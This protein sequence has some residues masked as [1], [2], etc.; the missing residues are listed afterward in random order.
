MTE[1]M[2]EKTQEKTVD[3][4]A[5]QIVMLIGACIVISILTQDI[6]PIMFVV[7]VFVGMCIIA[8]GFLSV[9]LRSA[10][11]LKKQKGKSLVKRKEFSGRCSR[12]II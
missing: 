6:S 3:I 1:E 10:E 9:F 4:R 2:S 11:T 5:Y 8:V 7:L 12:V